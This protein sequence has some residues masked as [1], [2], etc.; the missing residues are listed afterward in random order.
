MSEETIPIIVDHVERGTSS[1]S[2]GFR[3]DFGAIGYITPLLEEIQAVEDFLYGILQLT[4]IENATGYWLD[5]LGRIVG[6]ERL[7]LTDSEYRRLIEAR[8]IANRSSGLVD[9]LIA[10]ARAATGA[11]TIDWIYK[12]TSTQVLQYH[13]S[14]PLSVVVRDELFDM[15]ESAIPAAGTIYIYECVEGNNVGFAQAA[16][17]TGFNRGQFSRLLTR[18]QNA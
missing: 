7:G 4:R 5:R 14:T 3:G 8:I 16:G 13:V 10:I 18:G 12:P 15:L 9:E 11:T 2:A 6:Q 17:A 1:L